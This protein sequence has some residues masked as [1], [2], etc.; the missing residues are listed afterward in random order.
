[1][2]NIVKNNI[3]LAILE[4]LRDKNINDDDDIK[5]K[6][7]VN[8]DTEDI[9]DRIKIKVFKR[10]RLSKEQKIIIVETAKNVL[11]EIGIEGCDFRKRVLTTLITR[12]RTGRKNCHS[13]PNFL[14]VL[15][16]IEY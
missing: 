16:E 12:V 4:I 8:S 1:M 14:K 15:S 7:D 9:Y 3:N 13:Y 5:W 10:I 2:D 11:K 6:N